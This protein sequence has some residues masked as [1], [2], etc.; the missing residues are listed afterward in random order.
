MTHISTIGAG[1]FSDLSF[2]TEVPVTT[3]GLAAYAEQDW[4]DLFATYAALGAA[5]GAGIFKRIADI[6]SFPEMGTPPNIV[7]VPVY[8][9]KTS[10]QVQGQAD[11][12]SFEVE[13]NFIPDNWKVATDY[14]GGLIGNGVL[15]AFRFSLLNAEPAGYTS[16]TAGLGTALGGT[17]G[18]PAC[19]N[20][21]Y[22][23]GGKFEA[24]Q[25]NPQLTD[26]NTAKLTIS[27][28]TAFV[29]AFTNT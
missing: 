13:I 29:G 16:G 5:G 1:L 17:A 14:L 22:F 15:Y 21:Q 8:G 28:Q 26:A 10:R 19:K 25:V 11:A 9:S 7:N 18:T 27:I 3:A 24:I 12:P 6:R 2:S 20:S 4:F 23:W